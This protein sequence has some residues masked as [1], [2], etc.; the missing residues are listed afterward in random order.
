MKNPCAELALG[1]DQSCTLRRRYKVYVHA[2]ACMDILTIKVTKG[3]E[4]RKFLG[5]VRTDGCVANVDISSVDG[6]PVPD[7]FRHGHLIDGTPYWPVMS[8]KPELDVDDF[9]LEFV[10]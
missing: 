9:D 2:Y 3:D 1:Y 6:V 5:V 8:I 7:K 10:P 4:D